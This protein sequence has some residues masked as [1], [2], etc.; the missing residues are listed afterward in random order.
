[1]IT[2]L[3]YTLKTSANKVPAY[4]RRHLHPVFQE[5][6]LKFRFNGCS[7]LI[8][9]LPEFQACTVRPTDVLS[10]EIVRLFFADV[11]KNSNLLMK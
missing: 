11:L 9:H 8:L 6:K 2:L 10:G 4:S 7:L 1:M 3:L 5:N